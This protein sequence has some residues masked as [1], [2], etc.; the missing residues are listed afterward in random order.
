[1]AWVDFPQTSFHLSDE[2][3]VLRKDKSS[4]IARRAFCSTC[5]TSLF[6]IDEDGK[7][8]SV[9]ITTL[10][11]PNLHRPE[12]VSYTSFAPKWFPHKKTDAFRVNGLLLYPVRI[13]ENPWLKHFK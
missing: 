2:T 3:G 4:P 10:D 8:M 13:R 12:S 11:R 6:A 7:N 1:V 9:T 5:G